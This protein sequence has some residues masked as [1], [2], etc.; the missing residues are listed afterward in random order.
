MVY[1]GSSLSL[2]TLETLVHTPRFKLLEESY[3]YFEVTLP[4]EHI[5]VLESHNLPEDWQ[6]T[7]LPRSTQRIGDAWIKSQ[8]SLA[9]SVP[10][11]V[12]PQEH[13]YLLNPA[14]PK[15]AELVFKGPYPF[16][17]DERLA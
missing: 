7:E 10:S 5:L 2:A 9:L 17:F 4:D 16:R 1:L 14:H 8:T 3:V 6:S 15:R 11:R 12:M 13:N